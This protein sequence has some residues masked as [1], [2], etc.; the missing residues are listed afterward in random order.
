MGFRDAVGAG[1]V[2]TLVSSLCETSDVFIEEGV[3]R[4]TQRRGSKDAPVV[5]SL[6][7]PLPESSGGDGQG[8]AIE[9]RPDDGFPTDRGPL[10][11]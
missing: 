11:R 9:A 7:E 2:V 8:H 6:V 10:A 3:L 5:F 1:R 4:E